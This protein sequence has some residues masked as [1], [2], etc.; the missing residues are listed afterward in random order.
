MDK[1]QRQL[2]VDIVSDVMCPWCYVGKRRFEKAKALRPD[3]ELDPRW[4][5]YQL[6]PSIPPEGIDRRDYLARKFGGDD[7]ARRIYSA[8][9]QAGEEE[10][11]PFAFD[12]IERTPNTLDAHRLIRWA[13]SGGHQ[14]ELVE[15]LFALY[16]V[17]GADV[18]NRDVLLQ[19]AVDSGMDGRLVGELIA[20]DADRDLV[21]Q[22]ANLARQMGISGVPCFIVAGRY[23]VVGAESPELIASAFDRG[24][25]DPAGDAAEQG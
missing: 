4:R 13:A 7:A 17:E 6:D 1:A 19:A 23:A 12:R 15:R 20:T 16:F 2:T 3:I 9:E 25:E 8:I 5:P 11:I 10:G 21:E 18:G 14:D 22:E 24:L